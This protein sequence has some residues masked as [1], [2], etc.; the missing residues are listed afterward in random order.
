[1]GEEI[2]RLVAIAIGVVVVVYILPRMAFY[3]PALALNDPTSIRVSFVQGRLYWGRVL[4]VFVVAMIGG[5]VIGAVPAVLLSRLAAPPIVGHAVMGAVSAAATL[6]V[7]SAVCYLYW[8]HI[9][10]WD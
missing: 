9:R 4:A 7:H 6:V 10:S 1:M 2:S 5:M 3:I 8:R